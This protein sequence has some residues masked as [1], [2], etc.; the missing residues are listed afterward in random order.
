MIPKV[1]HYCWF[2]KN[3]IPS[4][5]EKCI[6]S[7]KRM[8][9]DYKIRRWDESN[10]DVNEHHFT[11]AAY[12]AKA[13]AFV[14]DYARLKIVYDNG[15]IY[16]DTDVELLKNLDFLLEDQF[17]I[18]VQQLG[19]LCTTG[20]GFGAEQSNHVVQL[21][22]DKYDNLI[23]DFN[24][25]REFACPTLNDSVIR[26]L[27]YADSDDIVRLE[28]ITVLPSRLVDPISPGN[29]RDLLCSDTVSI[30]HYAASW[31][32]ETNRIKRRLSIIVGQKNIN[33]IK[34]IIKK[35]R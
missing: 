17:Y 21:M 19:H 29:A 9:P 24:R 32:S 35:R 3:P 15:G 10:F 14:S 22:L 28:G 23:F 11:K 26:D 18:G 20:L 27:G 8:C 13:W 33:S 2:G 7:W 25:K 5:V 1:I 30:H 4:T 31:E 34:S 12:D 16:L 6:E